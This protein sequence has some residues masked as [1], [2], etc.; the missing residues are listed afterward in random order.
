MGMLLLAACARVNGDSPS[1][2]RSR[3]AYQ[4]LIVRRLKQ[5]DVY[6]S[7]DL[8]NDHAKEW[9]SSDAL[10]HAVDLLEDDRVEGEEEV[11]QAVYEGH[12][13]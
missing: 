9:Q 3:Q 10:T 1:N 5:D 11:E 2:G 13:D 7:N 4:L 6:A 12:I 8:A